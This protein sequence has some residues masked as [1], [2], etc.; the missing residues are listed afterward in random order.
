MHE[1]LTKAFISWIGWFT[2]H[3][4]TVIQQLRL[5][6]ALKLELL[7]NPSTLIGSLCTGTWAWLLKNVTNCPIFAQT[8]SLFHSRVWLVWE[9]C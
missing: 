1:I 4:D 2:W 8:H 6:E 3:G 7:D 5:C 9:N